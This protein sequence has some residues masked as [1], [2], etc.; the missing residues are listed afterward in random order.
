MRKI[1]LAI[2][3][4]NFIFCIDKISWAA[5]TWEYWGT[6]EISAPIIKDKIDFKIKTESRFN[7][8]FSMHYYES[9]DPGMDFKLTNW[10]SLGAYCEYIREKKKNIR[11]EN[12]WKT[13]YRPHADATFKYKFYGFILSD[14]NRMEYRAKVGEKNTF[15][16]RNRLT[17]QFPKFSS[18]NIQPYIA[19]EPFY[20]FEAHDLNNN[21]AYIGADFTI[22][23]NLKGGLYY[24]CESRKKQK[25]WENA[26]VLGT[27]IKFGF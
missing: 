23:K 17:L 19:D 15:R 20:E 6:S 26:N 25:E 4:L 27:N 21:R 14:R 24:M 1:F 9:I 11:K 18:L 2:L 8:D 10:L 7:K 16:Y 22:Y 3:M 13:E 12:V 5:K